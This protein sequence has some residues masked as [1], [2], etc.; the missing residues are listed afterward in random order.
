MRARAN[1]HGCASG[2]EQKKLIIVDFFEKM[3]P[4]FRGHYADRPSR[5]SND[6]CCAS[7]SLDQVGRVQRVRYDESVGC[8]LRSWP[9]VGHLVHPL[10]WHPSKR[11]PTPYSPGQ[12]DRRQ[13]SVSQDSNAP[14]QSCVPQGSSQ[15]A[16]SELVAGRFGENVIEE[17]LGI[18]VSFHAEAPS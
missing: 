2:Q 9:V 3:A 7:P 15:K 18:R 10:T 1:E 4:W 17:M 8:G 5:G 6:L 16:G 12:Q 14:D 13:A 11:L